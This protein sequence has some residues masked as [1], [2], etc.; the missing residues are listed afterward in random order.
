[1]TSSAPRSDSPPAVAPIVPDATETAL[2]PELEPAGTTAVRA[3]LFDADGVLQLIGTPWRQALAEAGGEA[4]A[5]ALLV[6]EVSALEGRDTLRQVL[7][8]LVER[9]NLAVGTEELLESWWRATPD[10]GAWQVVRDLRAAGYRTVLA[11]NQQQER[12][13]WMREVLGYDG[14]CDIDAY[15]CT[16]GVAKPD[17]DY[18]RAVLALTQVEPHEALFVDDSPTNVEVAAGLG[19]ATILHPADS[20]GALL[21]REVLEALSGARA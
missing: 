19:I 11:T 2:L 4:F 16:L 9:M 1:M 7:D 21:R 13:A 12:R 18:F 6:E 17:P 15:S 8:R 5:D 20:G 14:L 3:V 10:P